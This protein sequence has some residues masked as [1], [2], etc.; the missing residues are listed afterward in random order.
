MAAWGEEKV[1]SFR[2]NLEKQLREHGEEL[3]LDWDSI[4]EAPEGVWLLFCDALKESNVKELHLGRNNL[5]QAPEAAWRLFCDALKESKVRELDLYDNKLAQAPEVV[6]RLFCDTL[7]ESEVKKLRLGCNNLGRA[8]E[9]V[10]QLICDT[11]KESEVKELYLHY[12]NLSWSQQKEAEG[13]VSQ[14]QQRVWDA[15]QRARCL[16]FCHLHSSK[17][18]D[19]NPTATLGAIPTNVLEAHEVVPFAATL[20][21]T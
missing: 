5:G 9:A 21:H 15:K 19:Q 1:E 17:T 8:P 7:K 14:N 6:W 11:L 10:W 3:H 16:L 13:I 12:N 18:A 2:A 20:T 4:G